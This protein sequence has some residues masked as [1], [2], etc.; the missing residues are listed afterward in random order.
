MKK[1]IAVLAETAAAAGA[2]IGVI[3]WRKKRCA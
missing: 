2:V 1:K 3:V